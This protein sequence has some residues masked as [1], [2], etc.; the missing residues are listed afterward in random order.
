MN[1]TTARRAR[2]ARIHDARMSNTFALISDARETAAFEAERAAERAARDAAEAA[3]AARLA[4][5]TDAERDADLEAFFA[6]FD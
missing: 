4:A 2:A 1:N 3:T 6:D 5:M